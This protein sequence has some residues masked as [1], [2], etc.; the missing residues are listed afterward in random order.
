MGA[1]PGTEPGVPEKDKNLI[2]CLLNLDFSA[3]GSLCYVL[4]ILKN[5]RQNFS[6]AEFSLNVTGRKKS[7]PEIRASPKRK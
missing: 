4:T 7:T 1:Y 2:N 3:S 6:L 5:L